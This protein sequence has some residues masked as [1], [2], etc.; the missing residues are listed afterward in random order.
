MKEALSKFLL[1]KLCVL[2]E[3]GGKIVILRVD[4]RKV[5]ARD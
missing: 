5:Y 2:K 3:K 4:I 1:K